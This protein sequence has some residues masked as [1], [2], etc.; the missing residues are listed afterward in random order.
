MNLFLKKLLISNIMAGCNILSHSLL[1]SHLGGGFLSTGGTLATQA[2]NIDCLFAT[3][4]LQAC[5]S[6]LT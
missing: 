4:V 3:G 1:Q 5:G 2:A 6:R